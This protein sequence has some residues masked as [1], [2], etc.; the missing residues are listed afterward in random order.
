[1][2]TKEEYPFLFSASRKN[3]KEIYERHKKA[4]SKAYKAGMILKEDYGAKKVWIFGSLCDRER[5]NK[6]SDIDLAAK[7]I[8][9]E[10]FFAAVAAVTRTIKDYKVDLIDIDD[11]RK[12]L[13]NTVKKE[14]VEICI[15]SI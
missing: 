15:Q 12:S 9:D 10:R 7:G 2:V 8:S 3:K 6:Y 13:Y 14:G 1:M 5:F 11:C 4:L